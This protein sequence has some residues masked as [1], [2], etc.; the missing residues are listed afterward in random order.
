MKIIINLFTILLFAFTAIAHAE[1]FY[2]KKYDVDITVNENSVLDIKEEILVH[3]YS[4]RHG[5]FRKIPYKY[6]VENKADDLSRP[7]IYGK[8]YKLYIYDIKTPGFKNKIYKKGNYLYIRI[9]DK[10]RYVNGDIRYTIS[11]KVYGAI[12]FFDDHSEFYYNVIGFEWPVKIEKA[13]FNI[14]FPPNFK[15]D[16]SEYFIFSGK[17]FSKINNTKFSVSEGNISG[18]TISPLP[19]GYGITVGIKFPKGLINRGSFFTKLKFIIYNN[20]IYV[21]PVV[22][23]I[24]F[25]LL[26]NKFGKDTKMIKI[27]Q[28]KLPDDITPAEAGVLIDDKV[29]NR[30][31]ISL[32]FYWAAKGIL[33]IEEV[34]GDGLI[35]KKKDYVLNRLKDLP[36]TAKSFEKVIFNGLFPGSTKSV[37]ISTLKDNFYTYMNEAREKLDSELTLQDYYDSTSKTLTAISYVVAISLFII[38]VISGIFFGRL[39]YPISFILSSIIVFIFARIMPKK[40]T[41]GS[42]VYQLVE[43]F[44]E[45]IERVEKP[46]LKA[47]LKED[48]NYFDKI[49][50]FAIAL[51]IEE[52]V[53]EKFKDLITEPP[54]WYRGSSYHTFNT[55]YF[56]NSIDNSIKSINAAFTSAP[57]SSSSGSGFSGGGGFG[58]GGFGGGGGGSW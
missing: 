24:I 54:S 33:E 51:G 41:K 14:N 42:K 44:K 34:E 18:E 55:I 21:L 15:P 43:G 5:I 3:F 10:N 19:A 58:G 12:N 35:F 29:D 48:P 39:D 20:Y 7:F 40:T 38:G 16:E 25:F 26:W 17:R 2:I 47:L 56:V 1:Y 8:N 32:I 11:Y 46:K 31:L 9:G 6:K 22:I 53:A 30:D 57:Q 50:P 28:Y 36:E 4:P 52:K 13:T 49:L 45:F 27:V 23:F 37:K